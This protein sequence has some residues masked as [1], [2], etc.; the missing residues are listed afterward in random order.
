MRYLLLIFILMSGVS[1][2][3]QPK[4]D[5]NRE[6]YERIIERQFPGFRIMREEDYDDMYKGTFR[7]GK[8]GSLVFGHFDLD[9]NFDFAADLIGAKRKYQADGKT[10]LPANA[11]IYDGA[12]AICHGDKLGNYACEKMFDGPH[13]GREESE[14]SVVPRG[15]YDCMEDEGKSSHITAQFDSIGM[16]SEKGGGFYVRQPDGTYK[17][18]TTSD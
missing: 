11:T 2:A 10:P 13:W 15:A 8:D 5:V 9:K 1:L 14:L 18:C 12:I 7:D 4:N 3:D 6:K 17:E 16:Y